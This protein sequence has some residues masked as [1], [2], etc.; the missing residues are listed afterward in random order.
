M[1]MQNKLGT[2]CQRV[3]NDPPMPAL[4]VAHVWVYVRRREGE[5][6]RER[7]DSEVWVYM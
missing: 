5:G 3:R 4:E 1:Q 2:T 7:T 6:E